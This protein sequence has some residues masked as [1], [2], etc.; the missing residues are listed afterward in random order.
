MAIEKISNFAC[1]SEVLLPGN[2]AF[3]IESVGL[4]KG[5]DGLFQIRLLGE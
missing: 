2:V 4:V 3:K 1:E 5:S